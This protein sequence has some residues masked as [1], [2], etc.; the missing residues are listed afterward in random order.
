MKLHGVYGHLANGD[1]ILSGY[2]IALTKTKVE[3]SGFE[4]GEE[5]DIKYLKDRIIIKKK[6]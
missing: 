4:N 2:K 5:V 1:K 6:S 3:Q